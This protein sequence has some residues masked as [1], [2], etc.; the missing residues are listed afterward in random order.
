MRP[1]WL[2][3]VV[4]ALTFGAAGRVQGDFV[5]NGDFED[6]QIGS[7]FISANPADIPGWTHSGTVGD[8]LLWHVGYTDGGGNVTVAGN[9]LQFVT[10]GG[11][12]FD[13]G[14]GTWEQTL[15]GLTPG[16]TYALTFQMASEGGFSGSQSITVDF[17]SGSSTGPQTFTAG[18]SSASYWRNWEEK[19]ENFVATSSAVVLRFS[20]STQFDVGLDNI[21]VEAVPEPSTLALFTLGTAGLLGFRWWRREQVFV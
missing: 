20:G 5:V 12:F 1:F 2:L 17:P 10:L 11:G 19:T 21:R 3:T 9:G 14:T 4:L 18:P 13:Y 7:P 8:A 16:D 6:V 15:T